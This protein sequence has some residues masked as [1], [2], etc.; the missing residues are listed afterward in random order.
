MSKNIDSK[1][2]DLKNTDFDSDFYEE[3][4]TPDPVIKEQLCEPNYNANY[5]TEHDYQQ[6]SN[7]VSTTDDDIN[8]ILKQS[9]EEFEFAEDQRIKELIAAERLSRVEKYN[10]IKQKLQKV[11]GFDTTNKEIY[12]IIIPI[13]ELYES[14]LIDS[15]AL[16]QNDY[17]NVFK[18]L[19]TIRLT[20]E[21]QE[22]IHD[23]IYPPFYKR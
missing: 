11:Q 5:N 20:K 13:F 15:Y 7:F 9:L 14:N 10:L 19:Q 4:R 23:L 6:D 21:E 18:L 3:V 22:L 1:N 2:I 17:I 16:E 8:K 12:S